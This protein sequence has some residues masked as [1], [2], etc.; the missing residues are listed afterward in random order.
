M[1]FINF[2]NIKEFLNINVIL[3]FV[4]LGFLDVV[5]FYLLIVNYCGYDVGFKKNLLGKLFN[6]R[7]VLGFDGRCGGLYSFFGFF[8]SFIEFFNIGLLDMWDFIIFLV[9]INLKGSV[10][11]IFNYDFRGFGVYFWVIWVGRLFVRFV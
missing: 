3:V 5:V 11:F 7:L 9:W 2:N 6:V 8:D 4:V 1:F 10:G